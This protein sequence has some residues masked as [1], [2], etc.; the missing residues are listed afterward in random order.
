MNHPNQQEPWVLIEG[1]PAAR[2]LV[3]GELSHPELMGEVFFYP[4]HQGCLVLARITGLPGD[5]FFAFHIHEHGDCRS[6]GDEPFSLAGGHYN[7]SGSPHPDHAGDMPVLLSSKGQAYA[8]FYTGRFRPKDVLNRSVIIHEKPDDF[9][10]QP[11][12]DSGERIACGKIEA[13]SFST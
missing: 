13:V 2:A 3:R 4:F 11:S 9:R 5:G 1:R 10:T 12:G 7:P 6:G 8:L